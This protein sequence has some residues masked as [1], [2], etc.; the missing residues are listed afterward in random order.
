MILQIK[1]LSNLL[2]CFGNEVFTLHGRLGLISLLEFVDNRVYHLSVYLNQLV[3]G[4]W[5]S[6]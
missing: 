4:P 6:A 2:S 1:I 3:K 5:L